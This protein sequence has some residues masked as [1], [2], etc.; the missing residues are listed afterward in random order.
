MGSKINNMEYNVTHENYYTIKSGII[1]DNVKSK[2][3]DLHLENVLNLCYLNLE[4]D[5]IKDPEKWP[6]VDSKIKLLFVKNNPVQINLNYYS[7]WM[8]LIESFL[9]FTS[10]KHYL[11]EKI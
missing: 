10:L 11:T 3:T 5:I 2:V 9:M 4:V 8:I 7:H 1:D 6:V